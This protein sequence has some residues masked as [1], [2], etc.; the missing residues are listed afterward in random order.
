MRA[1]ESGLDEA[2][3]NDFTSPDELGI[4]ISKTAKEEPAPQEEK[5]VQAP[6]EKAPAVPQPQ[7]TVSSQPVRPQPAASFQPP[8]A[9]NAAG[10]D[11]LLPKQMLYK[12]APMQTPLNQDGQ[13][14]YVMPKDYAL[15]GQDAMRI[16]TPVEE[17]EQ[18]KEEP[19]QSGN[20][21]KRNAAVAVSSVLLAVVVLVSAFTAVMKYYSDTL[22]LLGG[23]YVCVVEK[24][25]KSPYLKR[26]DI[27]FV[28]YVKP[29]KHEE[30]T[31]VA[32]Y[33]KEKKDF[34]YGIITDIKE[35]DSGKKTVTV[36]GVNAAS[37]I[38]ES[39]V[40]AEFILGTANNYLPK[41]G[42]L[43]NLLNRYTVV[44]ACA[45]GVAVLLLIIILIVSLKS[46]K[47][48]VADDKSSSI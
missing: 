40:R 15:Y 39:K 44:C 38:T 1:L 12:A 48:A 2:L 6:P 29:E 47:K 33:N 42:Y 32:F 31:V 18:K 35:D 30:E 27:V 41:A 24:S 19:K 37:E 22:E 21:K 25:T 36:K 28:K 9:G 17:P 5:P 7:K 46:G 16:N 14:P 26:G 8:V 11:S 3:K 10:R 23:R 4:K 43:V 45:A 34:T 13:S 20:S